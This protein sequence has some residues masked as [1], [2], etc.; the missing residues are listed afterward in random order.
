MQDL[1][2]H[3]LGV[4]LLVP[5]ESADADRL[6]SEFRLEPLKIAYNIG[7]SILCRFDQMDVHFNNRRIACGGHSRLL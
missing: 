7:V 1:E 2:G 4:L 3:C 5:I 6:A